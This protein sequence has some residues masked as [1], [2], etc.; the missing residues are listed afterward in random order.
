MCRI[1]IVEDDKDQLAVCVDRLKLSPLSYDIDSATSA[2][3]AI[4]KINKKDFDVVVTDLKMPSE[5]YEGF[6]VIKAIKKKDPNFINTKV[7]VCTVVGVEDKEKGYRA[8][9]LAIQLGVSDYIVKDWDHHLD[10]LEVTIQKVLQEPKVISII[11]G[12]VFLDSPYDDHHFQIYNELKTKSEARPLAFNF[13]RADDKY[14]GDYLKEEI[15]AQI[16]ESEFVIAFISGLNSNV[17]YE[18]GLAHGLGKNVIVVKDD[19]TEV[20]SDLKGIQYLSYKKEA[21]FDLINKIFKAL[22]DFSPKI[23]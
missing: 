12:Q 11:K 18:L 20:V 1:L 5:D 21:P 4:K 3:K 7:I 10:I 2:N 15:Y 14:H 23:S 9:R 6:K 19:K 17:M 13:V 8:L 16:A 22:Q